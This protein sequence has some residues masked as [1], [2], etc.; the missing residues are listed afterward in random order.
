MATGWTPLQ[1]GARLV[2]YDENV[3][4]FEGFGGW[5]DEEGP[6]SGA[7]GR[8]LLIGSV[9]LGKQGIGNWVPVSGGGFGV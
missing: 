8:D 5:T 6:V 4:R 7:I 9:I 1:S 3:P 2:R